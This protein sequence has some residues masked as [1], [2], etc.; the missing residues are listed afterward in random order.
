[1]DGLGDGT[2]RVFVKWD[3]DLGDSQRC[4]IVTPRD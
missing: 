3:L 4:F 1:M 2:I